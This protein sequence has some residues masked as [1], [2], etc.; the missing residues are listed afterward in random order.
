[1]SWISDHYEK[2]ALAGTLLVAV[3][4]GYS[5]LQSKNAVEQDFSS[6]PEG[7]GSNDPSVKDGDKAVTSIS[8]LQIKQ[9]WPK[10]E[11]DGRPVDLFTGVPLFVN[12]NNLKQ[13]VDLPE[14]ADV[15]PPIPNQ[16]WIDYRIDPGFGDSPQRDEDSDGFT[17]LE[18]FEAKTDPT[19]NRSHPN[20]ILKLLYVANES[21]DWV[22]RPGGF[23]TAAEPSVTFEYSDTKGNKNRVTAVNPV[24][25]NETFFVDG[26]AKGRFKYLGFKVEQQRNERIQANVDIT[27]IEVED[28][29]PNKKGQK[30]KFPANFKRSEVNKHL[31]HDRTATMTLEALGLNGQEFQV[32][33]LT[34]FALP[35]DS[36]NKK[37][38]IMEVAADKIVV[39]ETLEDG[40]T[41]LHEIQKRP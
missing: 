1:M 35:I 25:I 6:T 5:G 7:S 22:L 40:T 32:E 17:N 39:Q 20:L 16:W 18:E 8:S 3:T 24:G 26:A 37:F 4:L 11:V 21:V 23:P 41:Q 36:D 10:G 29:K 38:R 14:S 2:A 33:E 15:H 31:Q 9:Q 27:I 34:D 13:P 12:K 19:D 28:L 30:Y